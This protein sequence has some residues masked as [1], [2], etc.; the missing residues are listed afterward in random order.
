MLLYSEINISCAIISYSRSKKLKTTL[1]DA[2]LISPIAV[3]LL[4][5]LQ[6]GYAIVQ[7][8]ELKRCTRFSPKELIFM[9]SGSHSINMI[10][11]CMP[12]Q[13][14]REK[15]FVDD[16]PITSLNID[17]KTLFLLIKVSL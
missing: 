14:Y 4:P 6:Q 10:F 8:F 12:S 7:F 5:E 15:L 17:L 3:A 16:D 2:Y 13:P 1:L 11:S 9:I